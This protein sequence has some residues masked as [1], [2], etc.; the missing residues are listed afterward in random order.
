MNWQISLLYALVAQTTP[1]ASAAGSSSSSSTIAEGRSG[2]EDVN[3]RLDAVEEKLRS[4]EEP[5]ETLQVQVADIAKISFSGYVQG[6]FEWH[7][8]SPGPGLTP[9]GKFTGTN[10]QFGVRRA[11][12]KMTAKLKYA[13]AMINIDPAVSGLIMRDLEATFIEPWTGLDLRLTMGLFKWPFGYEVL[14]SSQV[15]EMPERARVI[16]KLF[17]AERDR[18]VR[19]V[20]RYGVASLQMAVVNGNPIEDA[21]YVQNDP[22]QFKDVVGRLGLDFG[23][24]VL[25]VSGYYGKAHFV[26]VKAG[27]SPVDNLFTKSR[28]GADV[29]TYID[30]PSV[31]GLTLKGEAIYAHELGAKAFG[32]LATAAQHIGEL[33]VFARLDEYDPNLDKKDDAIM[34]L[35]GGVQYAMSA[36]IK[37]NLVFEH[38]FEH[39]SNEVA[40]DLFT[41]Q[42]QATY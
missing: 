41:A 25:G 17:P 18:G 22:N 2:R 8:D 20:G 27:A 39:G 23:R 13:E 12:I 28:V 7:E 36:N 9:E 31:G 34:T 24:L 32:W 16:R 11:R 1:A 15:R 21:V 38:P 26:T 19:M 5:V 35:G 40:N 30:V 42:L 37:T 10:T 3:A 4:L 6:R 29:E 33:T 14:Q